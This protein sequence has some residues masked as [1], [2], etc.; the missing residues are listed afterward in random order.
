MRVAVV[1]LFLVLAGCTVPVGSR[2]LPDPA[3]PV[4]RDQDAVLAALRLVDACAMVDGNVTALG[5]HRCQVRA[6][7]NEFFIRMGVRFDEEDKSRPRVLGG[8]KAYVDPLDRARCSAHLPVSF[9]LSIRFDVVRG[10]CAAVLPVVETA[11]RRL[12]TLPPAELPMA[13]WDP[14]T[15]L[16]AALPTRLDHQLDLD[17]RGRHGMD[18]CV[19]DA[20]LPTPVPRIQLT[21]AYG[22]DPDSSDTVGGMPVAVEP[23]GSK[24][25]VSWTNGPFGAAEQV[26]AVRAPDCDLAREIA[27]GVLSTPPRPPSITPQDPLLYGPDEPDVPRTG[28]CAYIKLDCRPHED[29]PLPDDDIVAA[30]EDP[31]V[32]CQLARE[33]VRERFPLVDPVIT[34]DHCQ[35]VT[36]S[37]AVTVGVSFHPPGQH[38]LYRGKG[39]RA[40]IAGLE[41]WTVDR[42]TTRAIEVVLPEQRLVVSVTVEGDRAPLR[43]ARGIV[44][45][46][47]TTYLV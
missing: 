46:I 39:T 20:E 24:C 47:V 15:L 43:Q 7:G 3:V 30:A 25:E 4:D 11:A 22:P 1:V 2:P 16:A 6:G 17:R 40:D 26:V 44:E 10:P 8:A 42:D 18:G 19:A 21:L 35:F 38:E 9:K 33:P 27:A 29:T 12:P 34:Y 23:I 41:S 32:A 45:D 37:R 31:D 13:D 28:P 14:C 5:P 36:T